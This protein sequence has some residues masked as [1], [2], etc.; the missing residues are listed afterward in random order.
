MKKTIGVLFGGCSSEYSISL[1]SAYAVLS[2]LSNEKYNIIPIGITREG[3][4]YRYL[5]DIENILKDNWS[6][7][8]GKLIPAII[9]PDRTVGGLIELGGNEN[10]H[11]KLDGVFPVLHGR[12]GEDGTVQ[13]LI[14][15]AGIPLIGCNTLSSALSMD[16]G[17]AHKIV[18]AAGVDVPKGV[19]INKNIDEEEIYDLVEKLTY[20]LFVKPVNEGS[21]Y[22]ITKVYQKD[23]LLD[24]IGFA[25]K[26]DDE[27]IIE[28]NIDGFEVGCALLGNEDPIIGRVDEIELLNDFFDYEDKYTSRK[29][30][31]HMPGRIDQS[32]GE[33]IKEAAK[34]IYKALSC[35]GFARVDMF[36]TPTNK[37]VFNEVNTIPGLTTKSRYPSM[38]EGIGLSYKEILN[39]LVELGVGK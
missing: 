3:K 12:N 35:S 20:P 16:K 14:E 8:R 28:E 39:R 32:T 36:L 30:I 9:S 10:K 5:G 38:M 31:I 34:T 22:G 7:D 18:A 4:W 1:Q 15:L 29:S 24:A 11:I 19:V 2:N 26:H 17:R 23:G 13:G 25:F 27:V 6:K 37:I 21:S 33:K